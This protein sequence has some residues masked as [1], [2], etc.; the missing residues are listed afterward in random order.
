MKPVVGKADANAALSLVLRILEHEGHG[1]KILCIHC[2]HLI[3]VKNN[4]KVQLIFRRNPVRNCLMQLLVS[5]KHVRYGS[6]CVNGETEEEQILDFRIGN[7][8]DFD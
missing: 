7:K 5:L 8:F 6:S 3:E 4:G 2:L 1:K